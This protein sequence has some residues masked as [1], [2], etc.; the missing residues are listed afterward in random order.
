M[1]PTELCGVEFEAEIEEAVDPAALFN[2]AI[3]VRPSFDRQGG[4]GRYAELL[5]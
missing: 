1:P 5:N 3:N 4:K 2:P